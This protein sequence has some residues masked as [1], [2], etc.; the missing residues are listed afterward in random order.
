MSLI[1]RQFYRHFFYFYF[2]GI[3]Y[4]TKIKTYFYIYEEKKNKKIGKTYVF[5]VKLLV[6]KNYT[7]SVF[8]FFFRSTSCTLYLLNIFE[9]LPRIFDRN[10][11]AYNTCFGISAENN[12][13]LHFFRVLFDRSEGISVLDV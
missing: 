7:R 2:N 8:S 3:T 11:L 6:V 10:Q 13:D 1:H 4:R 5:N 12:S 9:R